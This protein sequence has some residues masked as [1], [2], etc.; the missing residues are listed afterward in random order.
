MI[1]KMYEEVLK[2]ERVIFRRTVPSES[3]NHLQLC[4]HNLIIKALMLNK[5]DSITDG[6]NGVSWL[7]L[8]LGKAACGKLYILDSVVTTLKNRHSYNDSNY[9][10]IASTGKAASNVSGS[11]LHSN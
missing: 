8:I 2:N 4:A 10:V 1:D 3:L 5:N 9:L 7:Q 6:C 11:T